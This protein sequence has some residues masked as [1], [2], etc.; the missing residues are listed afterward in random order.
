MTGCTVV[1]VAV[2]MSIGLVNG[3]WQNMTPTELTTQNQLPK[4]CH[5]ITL[6]TLHVCQIW[7]KFMHGGLM[8][9]WEWSSITQ[10]ICIHSFFNNFWCTESSCS[11]TQVIVH[12][13]TTLDKCHCTTLWNAELV[14]LIKVTLFLLKW[15]SRLL[16]CTGNG[17]IHIWLY[18][19]DQNV[20]QCA[21]DR[22][23]TS[24][25]SL[26][27][28]IEPKTTTLDFVLVFCSNYV[29]AWYHDWDI[30]TCL[31]NKVYL[32]ADNHEQ[33]SQSNSTVG[34]VGHTW[35]FDRRTKFCTVLQ[36]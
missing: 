22:D 12:L 29:S 19:R 23:K 15:P 8:W 34:F 2:V 30:I 26:N 16:K 24:R 25:L 11:L 35:S 5:V 32:N 28:D 6:L 4:I 33:F 13:S 3:K 14:H 7:C 31:R 17:T 18:I 36:N 1:P 20:Q 10:I 9:K 27:R 21:R